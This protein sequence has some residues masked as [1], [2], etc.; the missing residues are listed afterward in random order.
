VAER[1]A[2]LSIGSNLGDRAA[3]L[4]AAL[5]RVRQTPGITVTAVSSFYETPPWGDEDQGPFL[6]AAVAIDTALGPHALLDAVKAIEAALGRVSTRRWGPRAI[7]I[8]IIHMNGVTLDD[9][10]LALPHRHW[11]E[12]AFVLVPL[13]EIAPSLVIGGLPV[14]DALAS[15]D[16]SNVKRWKEC[17][18]DAPPHG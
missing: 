2:W 7:D 11:R 3:H 14:S 18:A 5:D 1:A 12:R 4:R 17:P 9:D 6:N 13:A 15:C 10:R 16:A 8:D